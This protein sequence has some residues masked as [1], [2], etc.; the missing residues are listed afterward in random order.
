MFCCVAGIECLPAGGLEVV[1]FFTVDFGWQG[2]RI[3]E[4]LVEAREEAEKD[5]RVAFLDHFRTPVP[6]SSLD[7]GRRNSTVPRSAR[8]ESV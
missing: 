6:P 7:V 2:F 5:L 1:I 3:W 4:E 8:L